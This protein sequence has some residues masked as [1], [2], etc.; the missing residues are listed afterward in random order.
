ME[1]RSQSLSGE[2]M[3]LRVR[4]ALALALF[5]CAV[6][7]PIAGAQACPDVVNV[8]Q[9][10]SAPIAGWTATLDDTPLRLARVTFYDGPPEERAS[11]VP[12]QTRRDAG[13]EI[14]TW[15]LTPSTN[16]QIWI[17]CGYAN[18]GVMLAQSLPRT[19]RSCSVTYILKQSVA[20]MPLIKKIVCN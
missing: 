13:Q 18:T 3:S 15:H 7:W 11:L 12:D 9:A 20:G 2:T 4:I 6:P 8:N 1:R 19:T 10:L 14:E 5:L 16:R 17:A